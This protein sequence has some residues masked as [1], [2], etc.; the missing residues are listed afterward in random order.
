MNR[1]LAVIATFAAVSGLLSPASACILCPG[2]VQT[3]TT[4]RQDAG[5]SKAVL[6]GTLTNARLNGGV[7]MGTTDLSIERLLKNDPFLAG[8]KAVTLN[9]YVPADPKNPPKYVVFCDIYKGILDPYR[10]VQVKSPALVD[11]VKGAIDL[12]PKDRSA[13]LLYFFRFLDHPDPEIANDAYLEFAKATDQEVGQVARRLDPAK[14]RKLI[15]DGQTPASRLGL[16]AFLLGACGTD[17]DAAFLNNLIR[18]PT[19]RTGAS[20]DGALSGYIHIRPKEGW[21]LA[22]D[23]L[24]DSKRPFNQR[25]AV[26]GTVRFY[27]RWKGKEIDR[28]ALRAFGVLL[29]QGDIADMAIED[30]RQWKLWELTPSVLAQYGKKS[31]DAPIM[32][33]AI[34]RYALCCPREEAARF[35]GQRR[36]Q[37]PDLVKDVEES[38]EFEKG[39]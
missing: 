34:I 26:I 10:G 11:Y 5:M 29:D 36:K 7:S 15:V 18:N 27:H 31:H 13:A 4:L 32:R 1:W 23:I 25:C 20:I 39:K 33:R 16:F 8:K 35:I 12:D 6:Y 37:E 9:R 2:N 17:A 3:S 30:L 19:E 38:L 14:L 22:Q 28:E 24:R 21:Q